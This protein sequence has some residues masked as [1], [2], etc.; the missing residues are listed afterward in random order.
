VDDGNAKGAALMLEGV[1]VGGGI[2][3]EARGCRGRKGRGCRRRARAWRS[4]GRAGAWVVVYTIAL[5]VSR[6]CRV[7]G[8]SGMI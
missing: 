4:G 3:D 5:I 6:D 7:D 8:H 2:L 1:G